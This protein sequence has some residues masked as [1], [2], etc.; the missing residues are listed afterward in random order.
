M[1]GDPSAA[2]LSPLPPGR[3]RS[4][5]IKPP[6]LIQERSCG[7]FLFRNPAQY[8]HM[9]KRPLRSRVAILV[10]MTVLMAMTLSGCVT[11]ADGTTS[12]IF[13]LLIVRPFGYILRWIYD[14]V[15]SYGWAIIIFQILTKILMLPLQVKSKKG[16]RAQAKL[17]PKIQE[18]EKRYK[19]DKNKYQ[20][21]L[22]K[23]YSKEGVNPMAGCLPMLITLPIL[24]GLY[25]PIS[26]P[27]TYLMHLT[28]AQIEQIKEALGVA[29]NGHVS[30]ITLAQQIY[31]N[32]DAVKH[33]S[34]NIIRMD[35]N[36]L[37]VNLGATPEW[38]SLSIIFLFPIISA[39]TSFL[40]TKL[41]GWL[42]FKSTGVMP[43]SQNGMMN[44]MMPLMSLWIGFSMPAGLTLYWIAGNLTSMVQEYGMHLY[45]ERLDAL[46]EKQLISGKPKKEKPKTEL[47][48]KLESELQK[49][50]E[51]QKQQLQQLQNKKENETDVQKSGSKR[52]NH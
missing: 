41:T 9:T 48:K 4:G 30:E 14:I 23:L 2:A 24:M 15:G 52:K 45:M 27:L 49:Q 20:E 37:G 16:M 51:I 28:A 18:L 35:F 32:F 47:Q 25:W 42:Q 43:D 12:N 44:F 17:Q 1:A 29:V 3:L 7:E 46:E 36:F 5:S 13:I 21:E 8:P 22:S 34:D 33:I 31:E 50:K 10:A 6:L 40:L 26:Q 38:K 19:N 11:T 39:V